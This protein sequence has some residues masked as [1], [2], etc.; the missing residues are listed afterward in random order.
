MKSKK[1]NEI[2]AGDVIVTIPLYEALCQCGKV[3]SVE[4]IDPAPGQEGLVMMTADFG[5]KRTEHVVRE[6]AVLLCLEGG[7]E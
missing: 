3:L 7:A 4:L 6:S 2:V 5:G 1:A